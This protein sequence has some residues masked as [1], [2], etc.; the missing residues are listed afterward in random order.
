VSDRDNDDPREHDHDGRLDHVPLPSLDAAVD[1]TFWEA[2]AEGRLL[3]QA[4]PDCGERQFFPR[5]WCHYCGSERVEWVESDGIGHVHTHTV[6]RRAT[7]LP[8]FADEVP[9]VVAY[10]ELDEG[11]RM[12]TN[13]VD[14]DPEAV[15]HGLP[16]EVTFE[17]PTDS[18][19]LPRFRPR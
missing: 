12:C 2:A 15:E 5:S 8:G 16:V 13:V 10:V 11:V 1:R 14:C 9:Y 18:V 4:C 17:R 6:I 3:V 19:G 7:E